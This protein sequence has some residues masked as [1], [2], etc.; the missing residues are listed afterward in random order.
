MLRGET[1]ADRARD[2]HGRIQKHEEHGQRWAI[3]LDCGASW[4]VVE[5]ET[6]GGREYEDFEEIDEG[7]GFCDGN[8]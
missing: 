3:C 8:Q 1:T 4:A 7:D 6:A 2:V 5:C